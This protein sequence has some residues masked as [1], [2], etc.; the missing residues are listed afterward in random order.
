[1]EQTSSSLIERARD[2]ADKGAWKRLLD[3]YTPLIQR[4]LRRSVAGP[5]A[6]DV[7]QEVLLSVLQ[8][9][10]SFVHSGRTGA[11]R[12]WLRTT[13]RH[14]LTDFMR[15]RRAYCTLTPADLESLEDPNSELS[16]AWD[17][18]HDE[19]VAHR[20]LKS[21]E[22]EFSRTT[23]L[24]F[25]QIVL[26]G[27]SPAEVAA[28]LGS[29]VNAVTKAK[30]RVMDRSENEGPGLGSTTRNRGHAATG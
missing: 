17:R 11:F 28:E 3:L 6:D 24:A 21:M 20:L 8:A 30:K 9:M 19:Y 14:R 2:P 25:T 26:K 29:T 12:N 1:M 27:R 15:S 4:W 10:P 16:L 18:E 23:W 7:I 5:D 13:T 22:P